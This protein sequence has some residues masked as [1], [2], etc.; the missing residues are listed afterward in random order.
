ML[1]TTLKAGNQE[2]KLRLTA[3]ASVDIERKLGKSVLGVFGDG[4]LEDMPTMETLV[5]VLHGSLQAYE[6][7]ISLDD[8]YAIY[9]KY[10]ESDGSYAGMLTELVEVLKVSGFFKEAKGMELE[11]PVKRTKV[12]K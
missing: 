9:D 7:G 8:A 2:Y 11:A 6:H 12:S 5:L 4:N 10:I 1:Y 3:K